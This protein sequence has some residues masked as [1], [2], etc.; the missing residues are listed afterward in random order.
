M[1]NQISELR[2]KFEERLSQIMRLRTEK[3]SV[4]R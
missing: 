1:D 2:Q 4:R 3:A